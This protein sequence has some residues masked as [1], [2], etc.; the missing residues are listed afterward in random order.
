MG[1]PAGNTPEDGGD[2]VDYL[3]SVQELLAQVAREEREHIEQ[4]AQLVSQAVQGGRTIYGFGASHSSLVVED[5]YYRAGGLVLFHVLFAPGMVLTERPPTRT[6]RMEQLSGVA[7]IVLDES[8]VQPG[9]VL[10]VV[11]TSGRNAVPVEMALEAKERGLTVIALTSRAY[12]GQVRSRHPSGRKVMDVADVVI[13]THVP[14]G[15]ALVTLE[16]LEHRVGPASTVV[17]AAVL[18][19]VLVRAMEHLVAAGWSP[20]V[21]VSGNRD[22]GGEENR[23]T[24]QRHRDRIFYYP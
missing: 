15:D 19:A 17:G 7:R 13:D 18:H 1:R 9:D 5:A 16:G 23:R 11:S 14:F 4:A 22:G 6:S 24:L 20:P 3:Q 8:P 10:F 21:F 12:S 2:A